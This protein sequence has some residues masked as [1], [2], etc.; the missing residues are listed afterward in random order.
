MFQLPRQ[1]AFTPVMAVVKTRFDETPTKV[2]VRDPAKDLETINSDAGDP[3]TNIADSETSALRAKILQVEAGVGNLLKDPCEKYLWMSGH[4]PCGLFAL[5]ANTADHIEAAVM[6]VLARI[7]RNN[8]SAFKLRIRH[9]CT[10]QAGANIKAERQ[11]SRR[12]P[13]PQTVHTL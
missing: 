9:S 3:L 6:R 12:L 7:Q 8:L 5:E 1:H 13:M 4:V 2:R 10:D 11:M